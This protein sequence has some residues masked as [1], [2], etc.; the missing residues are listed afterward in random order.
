MYGRSQHEDYL[1][2][3]GT[4]DVG[5]A[6]GP[7]RIVM[8]QDFKSQQLELY[9]DADADMTVKFYK[10]DNEAMPAPNASANNASFTNAYEPVMVRDNAT[11]VT[12]NG[13]TGIALSGNEVMTLEVQDNAARWIF[14]VISSYSDGEVQIRT[15]AFNNQ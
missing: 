12:Y 8:V 4:S 13:A 11:G 7:G 15:R 6:D 2:K 3:T 14:A 5:N 10:S 9:A 1:F